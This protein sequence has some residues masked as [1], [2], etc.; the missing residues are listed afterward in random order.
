M[1]SRQDAFYRI[2]VS[3]SRLSPSGRFVDTLG[4]YDPVGEPA[5]VSVDV[6]RAEEWIRKGA[7]PSETV[8]SLLERARSPRT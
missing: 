5:K 6:A 8:R 4:T 1:G 3:D 2:V 7:Q